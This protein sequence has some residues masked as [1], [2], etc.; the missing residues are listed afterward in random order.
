MT[1]LVVVNGLTVRYGTVIASH[2][3]S[4]VIHS[5]ECV[6]IVG[7]SGSGKTSALM[8][9]LGLGEVSGAEVSGS[10]RVGGVELIGASERKL[11]SIHGAELTLVS[12]SPSGTIRSARPG[13]PR[14]HSGICT[15]TY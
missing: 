14:H 6:A 1:E 12:Q 11:A 7:E 4:L 9:I 10:V 15:R 8:G 2:L 5:G 13:A 3:S